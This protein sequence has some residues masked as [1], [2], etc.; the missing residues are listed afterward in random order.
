MRLSSLLGILGL[1]LAGLLCFLLL[2]RGSPPT[3]S[4]L[5][6]SPISHNEIAEAQLT[7]QRAYP[8]TSEK[9]YSKNHH[10]FAYS[11]TPSGWKQRSLYFVD[12][13]ARTK[14]LFPRT[15]NMTAYFQPHL[16]RD[17]K[18]MAVREYTF[19]A[20]TSEAMYQR[21]WLYDTQSGART[22]ITDLRAPGSTGTQEEIAPDGSAASFL[23]QTKTKK[24]QIVSAFVWNSRGVKKISRSKDGVILRPPNFL[25]AHGR[26]AFFGG[27]RTY[28]YQMATGK[29]TAVSS[30]QE[31]LKIAQGKS[32]KQKAPKRSSK[33]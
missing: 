23:S 33:K 32:R 6:V 5:S 28:V 15:F 16:S 25:D 9:S 26:F 30:Y 12:T 11:P 2:S 29:R 7:I 19:Y 1:A 20:K 10:Y 4:L 3:A 27:T 17:G 18:K 13:K 31:A 24:G 21:F 14:K 22:L 8:G